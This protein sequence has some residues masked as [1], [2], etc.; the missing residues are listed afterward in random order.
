M[1][2]LISGPTYPEKRAGRTP[3]PPSRTATPRPP[4][5]DTVRPRSSRRGRPNAN[6]LHALEVQPAR[7]DERSRSSSK[8]RKTKKKRKSSA[9]FAAASVSVKEPPSTDGTTVDNPHPDNSATG[10]K[11]KEET[12]QLFSSTTEEEEGKKAVAEPVEGTER[13]SPAA[14]AAISEVMDRAT[15]STDGSFGARYDRERQTRDTP[16]IGDW[17]QRAESP[18]PT[19]GWY[20][21]S[22]VAQ[23][24]SNDGSS[25]LNQPSKESGL[26]GE[27]E[28]EK[29]SS[30]ASKEAAQAGVAYEEEEGEKKAAKNTKEEPV[31]LVTLSENE[32]AVGYSP[33]ALDATPLPGEAKGL[34]LPSMFQPPPEVRR[35]PPIDFTA[36]PGTV[37]RTAQVAQGAIL[38]S[39]TTR[40]PSDVVGGGPPRLLVLVSDDDEDDDDVAD[41]LN[42]TDDEVDK[43]GSDSTTPLHQPLSEPS[44]CGLA[45]EDLFEMA[46]LGGAGGGNT[47]AAA[48]KPRS[49]TRRTADG[50]RAASD[51][52]KAASKGSVPIPAPPDR[53]HV[54]PA[55]KT[56]PEAAS[57]KETATREK[58]PLKEATGVAPPAR[59]VAPVATTVP[60][61]VPTPPSVTVETAPVPT[62]TPAT[63]KPVEEKPKEEEK[64]E[65]EQEEMRAVLRRPPFRDLRSQM[66]GVAL[67]VNAS[68]PSGSAPPSSSDAA[69][70]KAT[71]RR[72]GAL[73]PPPQPNPPPTSK[74]DAQ[75]RETASTED[76][77]P[78]LAMVNGKTLDAPVVVPPSG[79]P[80]GKHK[81]RSHQHHNGTTRDTTPKE[82][83]DVPALDKTP[84]ATETKETVP[85]EAETKKTAAAQPAKV[86]RHLDDD[87]SFFSHDYSM[88]TIV[89]HEMLPTVWKNERQPEKTRSSPAPKEEES[90]PLTLP[91]VST[92]T[93]A[94][95]PKPLQPWRTTPSPGEHYMPVVATIRPRTPSAIE[96][97]GKG[98]VKSAKAASTGS[99]PGNRTPPTD[100]AANLGFEYYLGTQI[101]S[102]GLEASEHRQQ[103]ADPHVLPSKVTPSPKRSDKLKVDRMLDS[104]HSDSTDAPAD[105]MLQQV[106]RG[107]IWGRTNF[108]FNQESGAS[109]D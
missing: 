100:A 94:A 79:T 57:A 80:A 106:V 36:S 46:D 18:T 8:K 67:A 90:A 21:G 69:K 74:A 7:G 86:K 78:V 91:K 15:L 64:M 83:R 99:A 54:Y 32:D 12:K 22:S 84:K 39:N 52:E 109:K 33:A 68:K 92:P 108:D 63:T 28:E 102:N 85:K 6:P 24:K 72:E 23:L 1:G 87:R 76:D 42:H 70:R 43:P 66:K 97:S 4:A 19:F 45:M 59:T 48:R 65:E 96:S 98:S 104:L 13:A 25:R 51:S 30:A 53:A 17:T 107:G 26:S 40:R 11:T 16:G 77:I 60:P 27:E 75:S 58:E 73:P 88:G 50:P 34:G 89:T 49:R 35:S 61:A 3:G 81:R 41:E 44:W 10:P 62:L 56:V 38:E 101:S 47:A 29:H 2:A 93:A 37:T 31:V 95:P 14:D 20:H 82:E 103:P 71:P 5:D 105:V 55:A 9:R